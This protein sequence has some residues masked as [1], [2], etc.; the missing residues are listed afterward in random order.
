M[1][2]VTNQLRPY[3]QGTIIINNGLT[4]ETAAQA[5]DSG[6]ADLASFGKHYINNPDLADRV[7]NS[8][9]LNKNLD[10]GKFYSGG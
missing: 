5:I 9:K 2:Q 6:I 10:F 3:F 4:A 8:W 7:K 1:P